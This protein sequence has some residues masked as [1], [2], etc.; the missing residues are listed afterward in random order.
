MGVVM[1]SVI[2]EEETVVVGGRLIEV[3]GEERVEV[4][5]DEVE[6]DEVERDEDSDIVDRLE[7]EVTVDSVLEGEVTFGVNT[8][9]DS[10][11]DEVE[12]PD[13]L[14]DELSVMVVSQS[15][16]VV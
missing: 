1:S 4:E 5:R 6:R 2:D 12:T 14:I 9:V 16:V 13:E 3:E 15:S 8:T 10:D 11:S 7:V